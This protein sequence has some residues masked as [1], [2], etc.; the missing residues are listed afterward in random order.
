M[1]VE[2]A[3][4]MVVSMVDLMG[5]LMDTTVAMLE[6]LSVGPGKALLWAYWMEVQM[7]TLA[8]MMMALLM[9]MVSA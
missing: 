4:K 9:A 1:V 2:T 8:C 5:C 3:E 6:S 7:V